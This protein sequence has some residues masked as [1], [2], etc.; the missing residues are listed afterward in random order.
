MLGE[1]LAD[2]KREGHTVPET[3]PLGVMIEIPSAA[4]VADRLAA[5]CDFL[6][7]G[8]NDLIQ[9]AL[10]VDRGNTYV[11]HLYRPHDPAVLSLIASAVNGAD[12]AG[13][14]V[15]LCGEMGG[16]APYVPLLI[17]LGLRDLSVATS[18]LL[19]TKKA[20]READTGGAAA[21]AARAL[22]SSAASDVAAL[23]GLPPRSRTRP[24]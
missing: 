11:D 1:C 22:G 12:L 7:V 23:L 24:S 2:L 10:A 13:K 16:T 15:A 4:L 5:E 6:S 18:R 17:G 3:V 20:I 8:T 14:P 21:L 9:Y 19:S